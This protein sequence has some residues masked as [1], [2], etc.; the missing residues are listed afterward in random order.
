MKHKIA[1]GIGIICIAGVTGICRKSK[2]PDRQSQ[3]AAPPAAGDKVQ[4]P[5]TRPATNEA[6]ER[7]AKERDLARL[8]LPMVN[9]PV[10]QE[11]FDVCLADVRV[12]W[13]H[14][15]FRIGSADFCEISLRE[16]TT[17]KIYST[18]WEDTR[19][20][21]LLGKAW[22]AWLLAGNKPRRCVVVF[23]R[24]KDDKTNISVADLLALIPVSWVEDE[25][26]AAAAKESPTTRP[27]TTP[28]AEGK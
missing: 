27:A 19:R 1:V 2:T 24:P 25:L 8:V 17:G 11:G 5:T 16:I 20:P 10:S 12:S 23:R 9:M 18:P 6:A 14:C 7:H 3:T 4:E 13:T 26:K 22:F 15:H 21:G 28:A